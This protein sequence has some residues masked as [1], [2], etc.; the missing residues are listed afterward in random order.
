MVLDGSLAEVEKIFEIAVG[1]SN[2]EKMY[3]ATILC[4]ASLVR[5]WNLQVF[6]SIFF[7]IFVMNWRLCLVFSLN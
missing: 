3:A 5:G 1:G 7:L 2:E 4:G 6:K